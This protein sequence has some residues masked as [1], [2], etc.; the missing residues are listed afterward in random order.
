MKYR[1]IF[2]SLKAPHGTHT[3]QCCGSGMLI[4]DPDF[5]PSLI[6]DLGSRIQEHHQKR[7]GNFFLR[8]FFLATKIIRLEIILFLNRVKK[9]C[10]AKT[11]TIIVLFLPKNCH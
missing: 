7:G 8:T 5:Y 3:A 2:K 11:L 1:K 6:L 9:F 4:P 10:L